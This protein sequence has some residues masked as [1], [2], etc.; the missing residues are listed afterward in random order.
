MTEIECQTLEP[1]LNK[2]NEPS[3]LIKSGTNKI[4]LN[5]NKSIKQI[6][7]EDDLL[8]EIPNYKLM[9]EGI[10]QCQKCYAPIRSIPDPPIECFEDQGGCARSSNFKVITPIITDDIENLWNVPIWEDIPIDDLNMLD[11]YNKLDETTKNCLILTEPILYK[12]FNL[13]IIATYHIDIW[14][15]IGWLLFLG[16]PDSGKTRAIDL[17]SELGYRMV[18][19]GSGVT[20][21]AMVRASHNYATGILID[22]AEKKLNESTETGRELLGFILP[23]YRR[24]SKYVVAHKEDQRKTVAYNN[25]G[26]KAFGSLRKF[27]EELTSRCIPFQM[28]RDYP[29]VTRLSNIQNELNSLQTELINYKYKFNKPVCLDDSFI[30]KGRIKEIFEPIIATGKHIGLDVSD[31]INFA[32]DMEK[33][34]EEELQNTIEWEILNA[35]KGNEENAR[36]FDAPIEMKYEDICTTIGWDYDRKT[37]QRLGYILNKKLFLK[38][39]HK[40]SG[41]VLLLNDPK[42]ARKLKYLYRRYKV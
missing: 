6:I 7:K 12:V 4:S 3:W 15:T 40:T 29:E 24:R 18:H 11:V 28:E 39:K 38:T 41:T 25:F 35:I 31:V 17:I 14:E 19:G 33:E 26:F 22:Q 2:E 36:L 42:N 34:K 30:L 8:E 1:V 37:A 23:S 10:W 32:Q 5:T 20:F 13:S 21:P 16:L 27:N 9:P